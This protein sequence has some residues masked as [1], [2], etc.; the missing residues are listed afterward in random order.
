MK[1]N[2]KDIAIIVLSVLLVV[3]LA[4]LI[5]LITRGHSTLPVGYG[6][7][8]YDHTM[9]P[10]VIFN[11]Y[12]SYRNTKGAKEVDKLRAKHDAELD[13]IYE[14]TKRIMDEG[15]SIMDYIKAPFRETPDDAKHRHAIELSKLQQKTQGW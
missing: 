6:G 7:G 14:R 2:N 15:P 12:Y 10:N 1:M 8:Q 11:E 13:V 3:T 4:V 5:Y 9:L